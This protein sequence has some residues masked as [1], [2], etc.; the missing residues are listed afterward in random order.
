MRECVEGFE[1]PG[2]AELTEILIAEAEMPRERALAAFEKG[3]ETARLANGQVG[4]GDWRG[5]WRSWKERQDRA[6]EASLALTVRESR[7]KAK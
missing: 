6:M 3:R 4:C 7:S 2:N 5:M 1:Q